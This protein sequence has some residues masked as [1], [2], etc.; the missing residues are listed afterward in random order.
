MYQPAFNKIHHIAIIAAD[1]E[2]SRQFYVDILGFSIIRENHRP[3]KGDI[4]LDLKMNEET[5]IELFIKSDAPKRLTYPEAK[6]YRHLAIK[7]TNIEE[8][9]N[10]LISQGVKVEEIRQDEITDRKMLFFYDPDDLPIE[11]H[12]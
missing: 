5:E 6:G 1:Y 12:E 11:L 10:Y 9:R 3:E 8:D 7:T 2:K 4:K